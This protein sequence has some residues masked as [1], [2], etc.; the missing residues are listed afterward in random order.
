[1]LA[2]RVYHQ[3]EACCSSEYSSTWTFAGF[4]PVGKQRDEAALRKR[5]R[6]ET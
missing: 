3:T 2:L 5:M 6:D 4:I 1:M